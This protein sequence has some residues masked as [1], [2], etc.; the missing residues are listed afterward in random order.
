MTYICFSAW[1]KHVC[2]VM[3]A[4]LKCNSIISKNVVI[5]SI[6]FE[7]LTKILALKHEMMN[8][9]NY[10]LFWYWK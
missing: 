3:T 7:E 5:V 2:Y 4:E 6:N 1:S 8:I 10:I 9:K